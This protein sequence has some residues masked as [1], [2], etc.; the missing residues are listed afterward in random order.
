MDP[1]VPKGC[2]SELQ[3]S[4]NVLGLKKTALGAGSNIHVILSGSV[5]GMGDN[6]PHTPL[7]NRTSATLNVLD[8]QSLDPTDGWQSSARGTCCLSGI[9]RYR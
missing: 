6:V 2:Y 4:V 5:L 3:T 8:S 7:L 9:G 1:L